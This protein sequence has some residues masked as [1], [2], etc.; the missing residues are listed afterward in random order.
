ML[1]VCVC[2]GDGSLTGQTPLLGESE[3]GNCGQSFVMV[4]SFCAAQKNHYSS[5]IED[6]G[7]VYPAKMGHYHLYGDPETSFP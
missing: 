3:S 2:W 6:T 7:S 1:F 4:A 5:I